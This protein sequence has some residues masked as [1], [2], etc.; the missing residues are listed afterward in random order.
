MT[1]SEE[2]KTHKTQSSLAK[3]DIRKYYKKFLEKFIS[4]DKK[5]QKRRKTLKITFW[6]SLILVTILPIYFGVFK[7]RMLPKSDKDQMYVWIDGQ[8]LYNVEKMSTLQND[9][10][11]F[12]LEKS[13]FPEE[14]Q[15]IENI[16]SSV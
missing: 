11:K 2:I 3:Y 14:L 6:I 16:S 5:S 10:Q 9:F 8:R 15:V 4:D 7:A 13:N 1:E 12:L